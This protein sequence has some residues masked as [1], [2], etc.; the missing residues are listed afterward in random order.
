MCGPAG[1]GKPGSMSDR[2]QSERDEQGAI[3]E[4]PNS[5][6]DDWLGQQVSEDDEEA[7]RR[8]AERSHEDRPDRLPTEQRRT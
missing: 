2:P 5:T 6:V 3:E 4:P 8:F 1:Q 7:E